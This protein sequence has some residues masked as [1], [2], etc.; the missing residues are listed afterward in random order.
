AADEG[1]R[2]RI[3]AVVGLSLALDDAWMAEH[4]NHVEFDTEVHRAAPWFH[5]AFLERESESALGTLP[6]PEVPPTGRAVLDPIDLGALPGPA[7]VY[8][9]DLLARSLLIVVAAR[10]A[11]S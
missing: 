5:L 11:L 10:L 7:S 2:N 9:G 8:P 6:V 1:L 3:T 4:F